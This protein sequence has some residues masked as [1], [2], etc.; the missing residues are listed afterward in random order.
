MTLLSHPPTAKSATSVNPHSRCVA[1]LCGDRGSKSSL[2]N[3]D[4]MF[5]PWHGLT[6]LPHHLIADGCLPP[7]GRSRPDLTLLP[8]GRRPVK[9]HPGM[10]VAR[11]DMTVL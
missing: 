2:W 3:E 9:Y 10:V 1:P 6:A 7:R 4:P 8:V 5:P 11:A